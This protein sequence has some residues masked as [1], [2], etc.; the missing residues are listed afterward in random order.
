MFYGK[1]RPSIKEKRKILKLGTVSS[2]RFSGGGKIALT[3]ISIRTRRL[4]G[5]KRGLGKVEATLETN[6]VFPHRFQTALLMMVS[7]A[8]KKNLVCLGLNHV[9][10]VFSN[11]KPIQRQVCSS[12]LSLA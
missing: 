8:Q 3:A 1:P 12:H 10:H 4:R 2:L 9:L 7:H 5:S 11:T 6:S